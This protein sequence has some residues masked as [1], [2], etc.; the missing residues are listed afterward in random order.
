MNRLQLPI[1]YRNTS[2]LLERLQNEPE[3]AWINRGQNRALR[4]FHSMAERVPAYKDFLRE[5]GVNPKH[6]RTYKDF[7]RVPTVDKENYLKKYSKNKLCWDG[8]FPAGQWVIST[9]SGSTGEPYYFPRERSQDWQYAVMADLYLNSNYNVQKQKTLYIVAFPMGAWIGGVFTYEAITKAAECGGYDLSVITPGIHKTEVIN[10]VKQLAPFYDQIIVGAYAPFLKDILEDGELDGIDWKKLNIKFIFSAEAF[11]EKF[12]DY[13]ISK[14]GLKDPNRDTL[15]HYGTVDLGT[16]A[17]ETPLTV[18][19]RRELV[20]RV[21][22]GV[23]L[24]EKDRQPTICQFLPELFY[25][26]QDGN[27]LYCSAHSGIPLFR[28]DLKDYGGVITLKD[29]MQKLA[30]AGIAPAELD[31]QNCWNLPLVYVYER[32]DFSVSYYAFNIYPDTIRRA[33][34]DEEFHVE[35]TGKFTMKVDYDREGQ[36]HLKVH[37]EMLR[38]V[39]T[40][41]ELKSRIQDAIHKALLIGSAEY[42]EL[43][44]ALGEKTRPV[45]ELWS[46][47]DP[48]YFKVGSK[49]KWVVK[50]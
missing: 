13:V 22:L 25:F 1:G 3:E 23:L 19:I 30:Y 18:S 11:S 34:Q 20:Q 38:G 44:A 48:T 27:D 21:E 6:I 45:V 46:Y 40:N 29:S 14:V 7:G 50:S 37:V 9:T 42:P 47:E 43:F 28:Y 12:R 39:K 2:N 16:M 4:L 32:N 41:F 15:N 26:E 10:A 17:H 8:V 24:P 5:Y 33:L 49:Q 31:M 35:L 36:Q